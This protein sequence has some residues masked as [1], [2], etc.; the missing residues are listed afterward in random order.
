MNPVTPIDPAKAQIMSLFAPVSARVE[1]RI[2]LTNEQKVDLTDQKLK[3]VQE[4]LRENPHLEVD[5]EIFGRLLKLTENSRNKDIRNFRRELVISNCFASTKGGIV[6]IAKN[7]LISNSEMNSIIQETKQHRGVLID[8]NLSI[9][10]RVLEELEKEDGT[11]KFWDQIKEQ[12]PKKLIIHSDSENG[13]PIVYEEFTLNKL[14]EKKQ[15][16]QDLTDE[17]VLAFSTGEPLTETK[18]KLLLCGDFFDGI[19]RS[20]MTEVKEKTIHLS[21]VSLNGFSGILSMVETGKLDVGVEKGDYEVAMD[22]LLFNR[23][24]INMAPKEGVYGKDDWEK[25]WGKIGEVPPLPKEAF[26]PSPINK[27]KQMIDDFVFHWMA[28]EVDGIKLD[29]N[30]I[31]KIATSEK[32]GEN[33]L[34]YDE[35]SYGEIRTDA[36]VNQPIKEGYWFAML[37]MPNDFAEKTRS[38]KFEDQKVYIEKTLGKEYGFPTTREAILY[39][40]MPRARSGAFVLG[41]DPWT[42]T[43]CEE[44]VGGY[45]AC[46]GGA[47]LPGLR[48][49]SSTGASRIV[50]VVPVRKFFRP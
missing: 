29:V 43:R 3:A 35:L 21:G 45:H 6:K 33:K 42:Y 10:K 26:E 36:K 2:R 5:P 31:E 41:R 24:P 48:L 20:G 8:G 15:S 13:E 19:F 47:A 7:N 34:K 27:D 28:P 46:V 16:L 32:F 37:K 39:C 17:Y 38:M 9:S 30:S 18:A 12:K 50:C 22:H 44:V 40:M 11:D 4:I 1:G 49:Y 14:V 23:Q 25:H